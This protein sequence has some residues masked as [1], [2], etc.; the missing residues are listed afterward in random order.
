MLVT[1]LHLVHARMVKISPK[2]VSKK[3]KYFFGT[4]NKGQLPTL[5]M[6]KSFTFY[7]PFKNMRVYMRIMERNIHISP[8]VHFSI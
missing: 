6:Q 3:K 2:K 1:S 7:I 8:S 4:L 5:S